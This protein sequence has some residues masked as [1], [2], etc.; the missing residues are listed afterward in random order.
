MWGLI[1]DGNSGAISAPLRPHY[2]SDA[3][4]SSPSGERRKAASHLANHAKSSRVPRR[5][6]NFESGASTSSGIPA[7]VSGISE[8]LVFQGE[9]SLRSK[10]RVGETFGM[11]SVEAA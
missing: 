1:D 4:Q 3:L 9:S 8:G 2:S 10:P 6:W 5:F 11:I 7:S